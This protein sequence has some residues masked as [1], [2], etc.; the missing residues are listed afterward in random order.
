MSTASGNVRVAQYLADR[1]ADAGVSHVF[2]LTG[3]GA[4]FL[5]DAFGFHPRITPVYQHHEQACAMAAEGYARIAERP[6]VCIVTT[7]PGGINALN[8]VFGAW[9]DSIPMIVLSGQVKRET[10][11]AATPS[12]GLRQLGDQEAEI[13]RMAGPITK[14]ATVVTDATR[15]AYE[16]DRAW[17][18]ATSGRPGPVWLD[19]PIDVQSSMID[20]STLERFEAAPEPAPE[21]LDAFCAALVERIACAERPVLMGGTGVRLAGAIDAFIGMAERLGVPVVTAWTHD[22]IASDH[23]LFCGRP[24]TIGTRAGNFTVQN[25]DLLIVV[26]SRLNIRQTSYN[27]ASFAS[28]AHVVHVDIDAAELGKPTYHADETLCADARAFCEAMNAALDRRDVPVAAAPSWLAWCRERS[29][30]YPVVTAAKRDPSKPINPYAFV[31]DLFARLDENDI[32][33]TGN[34]TACIVSFQTARLARGQRLFSNSGSASMGYDLPAA[35]GAY[36]GAVE[37]RGAQRRVICIAGDG[38]LMLNMQELQ[39]LVSNDI[40]VKLVVLNNGGYLSIRSSQANFFKRRAGESA[41]SGI[42]FPD[43]RELASAFG[44]GSVRIVEHGYEATL[45]SALDAPGPMLIEVVLDPEQGFEPR[46]SSRQLEDGRIESPRLEDMFPFLSRE[47]LRSNLV[48][49]T[50]DERRS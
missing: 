27:W 20:P 2:T 41:S 22:L 38:S 26:G 48:A 31:E 17:H 3:G 50:L 1:V 29:D 42:G 7:G 37:M 36:Y 40:P 43:F 24:G 32:A 10:C 11:L 23:P 21:D 33:V 28:D 19:I 25:A 39:T 5:N 45:A 12:P 14:Y 44:L 15:V 30:R 18:L 9:T 35:I 49:P 47:E 13:V 34:A 4:M 6:G 8:G 16:F 46:M